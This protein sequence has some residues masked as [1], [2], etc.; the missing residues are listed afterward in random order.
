ME[1]ELI[2]NYVNKMLR[3]ENVALNKNKKLTAIELLPDRVRAVSAEPPQ[4]SRAGGTRAPSPAETTYTAS[5]PLSAEVATPPEERERERN[6]GMNIPKF[7]PYILTHSLL[8][9]S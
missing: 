2:V 1:I 8:R 4:V 3:K 5:R 7:S 9:I 6:R